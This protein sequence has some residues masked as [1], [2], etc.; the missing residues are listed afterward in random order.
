MSKSNFNKKLESKIK[1]IVRTILEV[2][3]ILFFGA[4]IA[5]IARGF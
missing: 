2:I 5:F 1:P 4:L 3:G